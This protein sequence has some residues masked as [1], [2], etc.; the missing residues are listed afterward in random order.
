MR[1][2]TLVAWAVL[3]A[4]ALVGG[5]LLK[6]DDKPT[7]VPPPIDAPSLDLDSPPPLKPIS[8]PPSVSAPPPA[9]VT[10]K[11]EA[12]PKAAAPTAI[13]TPIT[14]KKKPK[15]APEPSLA[16]PPPA[17]KEIKDTEL[18]LS[19]TRDDE[20]GVNFDDHSNMTEQM[21]QLE[22]V[23]PSQI[24]VGQPFTYELVIRN[25]G[26]AK[27]TNVVVRDQF[28]EG[29]KVTSVEPRG[30]NDGESVVW[31][32]GTLEARQETRIKVEMVASRK[33]EV[34]CR[35]MVSATSPARARYRVSEPLLSVKQ[36]TTEK[37]QV[38]DPTTIT[39]VVSNPG[40][41]PT[42]NVV[43]RSSL[44]DGLKHEK[45]AEFSYEVGTLAAGETRTVQVV[46]ET[47]KGGAQTVRTHVVA[48]G[49]LEANSESVVAVTEPKLDVAINGPKLRYL[50]RGAVYTLV[51]GN[52]GDSPANNVRL[53]A[54]VPTGFKFTSSTHGGRHETANRTVTW[55]LGTINGGEKKE[56]SYQCVAAQ[57]GQ[58]KHMASATGQRGVKA[59]AELVTGVE[60]ISA[61]L[62]EVVDVDDPVESGADT[63][64][65]IRVTNQGSREAT[66]VEIH[67]LVPREMQI[68]GGQG[69]TNYRTEGQEIVFAPLAK[70]APRADAIYRIFVRGVGVG[71]VRFRARLVSD[72]LS[73]PVIEEESTKIYED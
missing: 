8:N 24:K 61:L 14:V 30:A 54:T 53:T 12:K 40:D 44:T 7:V 50:D 4:A 19:P 58:H 68:R 37:V 9:P 57:V 21:V 10:P 72:S 26:S 35:A 32:I 38:G 60:G 16:P 34:H 27:V 59:D 49:G 22:W 41:G 33:G 1:K 67:A 3:C 36:S 39:I 66:N 64:Y 25:N 18:S 11:V 62:L 46:C 69:P 51:C 15:P 71:D 70:L 52:P 42:D 45:G 63:A 20:I 56:V 48:E 13:P 43:I 29:M 2:N 6:A 17:P 5:K 47:V 65:E 55:F 23:G 31:N 28:P 73:E